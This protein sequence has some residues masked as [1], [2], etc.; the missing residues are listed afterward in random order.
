MRY[1]TA[2]FVRMLGQMLKKEVRPG[3]VPMSTAAERMITYS[4]L[5]RSPNRRKIDDICSL[6]K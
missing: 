5:F 4:R 2:T 3:V 6:V 1:G